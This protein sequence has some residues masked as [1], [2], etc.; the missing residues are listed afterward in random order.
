MY[1]RQLMQGEK[2]AFF[3]IVK[4]LVLVDND[5]ADVERALADGFLA[6]M[7]LSEEEIPE[8][9]LDDAINMLS[10]SSFSTKKKVFFELVGV[11]LCDADFQKSEKAFLNMVA[12]RFCISK[13]EKDT[14]IKLV[15][16]LLKI[17]KKMEMVVER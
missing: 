15:N 1:L 9:E 13:K 2:Y 16:N 12:D 6:E 11:T 17:Y 14:I 10:F 8:I 7:E 5:Y 4:K 3:S